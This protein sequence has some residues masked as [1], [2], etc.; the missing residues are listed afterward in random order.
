MPG[1]DIYLTPSINYLYTMRVRMCLKIQRA[2]IGTKK[3]LGLEV[4]N[5]PVSETQWRRVRKRHFFLFQICVSLN[6]RS[7]NVPHIGELSNQYKEE[8]RLIYKIR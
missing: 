7:V 3:L 5:F 8:L 4:K 2:M 6:T 1:I